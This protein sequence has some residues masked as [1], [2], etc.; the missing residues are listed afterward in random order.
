MRFSQKTE[1]ALR[2]MVELGRREGTGSISS[3]DLACSQKI[4]HRFLEQVLLELKR[5]GLIA[6]QRGPSGGCRLARPANDIRVSE[7][8]DLIEGPVVTQACLDPFKE[9][10]R[11]F[12]HSAIQEL[13]L[14]LQITLRERLSR[15]TLAD[16]GKRQDEL[17]QSSHLVFHI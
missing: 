5:G 14:D 12:M 10:D 17:D 4:P 6:S 15:T 16:L 11:A 9:S 3:R 8:V 2:A 13:W 1:Y 7:I